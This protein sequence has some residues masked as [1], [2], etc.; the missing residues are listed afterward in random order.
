MASFMAAQSSVLSRPSR[1]SRR[2]VEMDLGRTRA[3]C[4]G[5]QTRIPA[6]TARQQASRSIS[7]PSA[8]IGKLRKKRGLGCAPVRTVQPNTVQSR[9]CSMA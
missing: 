6:S 7:A 4:I 8:C 1:T 2:R 3:S 5:A 9:P